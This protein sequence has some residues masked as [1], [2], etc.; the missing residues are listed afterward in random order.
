[1]SRACK[2]GIVKSQVRAI[3]IASSSLA[4]CQDGF[5]EFLVKLDH[6]HCPKDLALETISS[7][8][9]RLLPLLP[10]PFSNSWSAGNIPNRIFLPVVDRVGAATAA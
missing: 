9:F 2:I 4:A 10:V 7:S 5:V 8:Y 1:M 3:M 6:I